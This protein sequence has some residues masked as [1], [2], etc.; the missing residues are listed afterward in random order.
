M[1]R[2]ILKSL[3]S[4]SKFFHLSKPVSLSRKCGNIQPERIHKEKCRNLPLKQLLQKLA[5]EIPKVNIFPL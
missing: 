3:R 2:F 5:V 4:T 1:I